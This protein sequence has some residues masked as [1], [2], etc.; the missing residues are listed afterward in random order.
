MESSVMGCF[1]WGMNSSE[2]VGVMASLTGF[3]PAD[4][5][6]ARKRHA[7]DDVPAPSLSA[8]PSRV[9]ILCAMSRSGHG[10]SSIAAA[11]ATSS[12]RARSCAVVR[13][14]HVRSRAH[15]RLLGGRPALDGVRVVDV[16]QVGRL[17]VVAQPQLAP[18][19]A[20]AGGGRIARQRRI[21]V[22]RAT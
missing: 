19:T 3:R 5:L 14:A 20:P 13:A 12:N 22:E 8:R 18:A 16:D 9:V 7:H 10:A 21:V 15:D 4:A 11:Y 6:G 17:L 2:W 1:G